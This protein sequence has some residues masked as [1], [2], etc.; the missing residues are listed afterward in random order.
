MDKNWSVLLIAILRKCTGEQPV[1]LYDTGKFTRNKRNN[2]DIE[3]M[4]KFREQGL[5]FKE[6]AEIFCMDPSTICNLVN[7]SENKKSFLQEAKHLNKKSLDTFYNRIEV[8]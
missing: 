1:E 7:S 8:L 6:I 2:E 4:I 3:D 5:K